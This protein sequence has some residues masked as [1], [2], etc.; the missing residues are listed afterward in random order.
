MTFV[1]GAVFGIILSIL[2]FLQ[3]EPP[4]TVVRVMESS[5]YIRSVDLRLPSIPK[6]FD[7]NNMES[8]KFLFPEFVPT[9]KPVRL[10]HPTHLRQEYKLRRTVFVGVLTSQMYLPTRAKAIYDT[11]SSDVSMLVFFVGEDCIVPPDLIH[12]PVVKLKKV[13][14]G[15]YPPL[16]KAF[17][18][19]QYMYDHFVNDYDWFIRADDDVYIRGRK[20]MDLLNAMDANEI[21]S[22][23]RAGEGRTDDMDR[24]QL[25]KHERYCMGGPGMVFSRGTMQA[26]GPYLNLCLEASKL[27]YCKCS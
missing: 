17:A 27:L 12:L 4:E 3:K 14:D 10:D 19:M 2:F 24:L 1:G 26:L 16:K 20:L 13:P 18:V 15:V 11:W 21:I 5:S 6:Q 25:L 7:L 8:K 22:L 9:R 23:G